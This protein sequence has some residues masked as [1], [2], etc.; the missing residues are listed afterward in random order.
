MAYQAPGYTRARLIEKLG[1]LM[2]WD[3]TD[4]VK[5]PL[6]YE[7]ITQAGNTAATWRGIDWWWLR[8]TGNFETTADTASYDLVTPVGEGDPL[9]STQ[10]YDEALPV[11]HHRQDTDDVRQAGSGRHLHD[12]PALHDAPRAD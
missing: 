5:K 8:A 2:A 7:A 6:I 11:R 1:V 10:L 9:V 3:P 4:V 12:L